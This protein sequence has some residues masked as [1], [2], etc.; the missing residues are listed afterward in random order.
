[1]LIEQT[2]EIDSSSTLNEPRDFLTIVVL[3]MAVP[4]Y[5][6][7]TLVSLVI[8]SGLMALIIATIFLAACGYWVRD[9]LM[10]MLTSVRHY[11]RNEVH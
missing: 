5:L 1:M 7:I 8:V 4:L 11:R 6:S 3:I 10:N 2:I 9:R